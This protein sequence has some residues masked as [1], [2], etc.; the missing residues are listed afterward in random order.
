MTDATRIYRRILR[1]DTH[2]PRSALAITLAIFAI[3]VCGWLIAETVLS[4]TGQPPL[5]TTI[6]ALAAAVADAT[7]V[8]A[9]LVAAVALLMTL[10]GLII[11]TL[12]LAPGRR[13]RHVL[14]TEK[15]AAIVDDGV[16]A[17]ALARHA[18]RAAKINPDDVRVDVSHRRAHVHLTP[19]SGRPIDE[20]SV[21][22][23]VED[24]VRLYGLFPALRT[25]VALEKKSRVGA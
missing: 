9:G 18:A 10:L 19:A 6:P 14:S 7:N 12:A 11:M 15:S 25:T 5:L 21:R 4:L 3:M 24:Q 17:S 13:A 1:R 22:S 20:E 8:P 2:S 23:A 16:I